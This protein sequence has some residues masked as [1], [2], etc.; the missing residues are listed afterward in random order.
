MG[1][2]G[3]HCR[4]IPPEF[5][6][7]LEDGTADVEDF[8]AYAEDADAEDADDELLVAGPRGPK[9]PTRMPALCLR[10]GR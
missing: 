8:D 3:V 5:A 7:A 2:L 9:G 10:P 4:A 6:A 1:K